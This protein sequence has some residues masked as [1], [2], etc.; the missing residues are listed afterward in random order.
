MLKLDTATY[1]ITQDNSAGPIIQYVDDGFEPHGPV[2][3]AN[4]NVS[5]ASAA[6]YLVAYALLAGVIGYFIFAL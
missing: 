3:D 1:L 5:R 6:A 2:T 4:G